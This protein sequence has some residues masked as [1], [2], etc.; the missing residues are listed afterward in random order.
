LSPSSPRRTGHPFRV[1]VQV[2]VPLAALV[3]ALACGWLK[4]RTVRRA[5]GLSVLLVTIDTLRVDALG[6]YGNTRVTT[7]WIDRLA[8][9]G[10]RFENCHAQNVVTLPSHS[11][12]LSGRYPMEHGVR[13]NSNF[14]F[15][16][17]MDT[18]ATLL[19]ASGYRTGGFVSAF[20]LDARFGLNRGFDVYD[21]HV[22]DVE[23]HRAFHMQERKGPET[24]AAALRWLQVPGTAPTFCWVHL[25]EPHWPYEPPEPFASRFRDKP[26]FGEVSAADAA[27]GP[28]LEPLLQAGPKGRTL[29]VLTADHGESL[30]EHGEMTHGI[31]AYE[32][33]LHVPLILYQPGILRPRIVDGPVRHVDILPTIL[34]ALG[35]GAP[36]GLPGQSLLPEAAGKAQ[37][38]ATS[39]F[40]ALSA[41]MNRGW[42]PLRGVLKARKKFIDLPLPEVYDLAS[43]PTESAN[44]AASDPQGLEVFRTLLSG[45]RS[46]E[47]ALA[48]VRETDEVRER[49]RGLGYVTSKESAAKAA[50]NAED[51]PKRLISV[52][53]ELQEV[54][55]K[56]LGGDLKGGLALCEDLVTRHPNMPIALTH[57]AFLYREEGDL[58]AATVALRRAVAL[59]PENLDVVALLGAYLIEGGRP[60]EALAFLEPYQKRP[61]P[62][63]D[64]LVAYGM[65]S[66]ALG[67][68]GEAL[69]V[70]ERARSL[71]PSSGMALVNI[72]TVYLM[73]GDRVQAR[74]AFLQALSLDPT[75]ARAHT[76]LGVIAAQTG[77]TEEAVQE[78]KKALALDPRSYETLYDLGT[79]L[80]RLGRVEEARPLLEQYVREAPLSTE[81]KD[82]ARVRTWLSRTAG[83]PG[84]A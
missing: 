56:Y 2:G 52:D 10:V 7:P 17:E 81:S 5:P 23:S 39:Y 11:N 30:G 21:D 26:Y 83:S 50:Y 34:D 22:S 79:L 78:W 12:I 33:T 49:L 47:R 15:P 62:D 53:A 59:N 55:G 32:A 84:G 16:P 63:L 28:L 72:G 20:P 27:L 46:G 13:D 6:A 1:A 36:A 4:D 82:I 76:S 43:D 80:I 57:L 29:V 40:E 77:R 60:K 73:G 37:P 25:Y 71:D 68:A 35:I 48:R 74:E 70:F 67:R 14:R 31:F 41:S 9:E 8:E 19:K 38:P 65:A 75:I 3:C 24:V 64:V 54:I 66:A 45:L 61:E 18:I 44:L 69:A 42:A 58:P 51:D